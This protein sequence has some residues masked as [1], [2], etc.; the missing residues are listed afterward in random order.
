MATRLKIV[1]RQPGGEGPLRAA[2]RR[3]RGVLW[4]TNLRRTLTALALVLLAVVSYFLILRGSAARLLQLSIFLAL[5]VV[6][7]TKPHIGIVAL[8]VYRSFARGLRLEYL[9]R[10]LG[11]TLT[12]SI[13]LF[14]LIGFVALVV[15]KKEKPVFGHKTQLVFLYGFLVATLISAFRALAWAKVWTATF[16][17]LENIILYIIFVNLFA[18]TK[19]LVRYT[20]FFVLSLLV[21]CFTGIGS[22]ALSGVLRAA[23]AMG[24]PNGLAMVANFAAAMLLV[25]SLTATDVKKRFLFLC[26]LGTCLVTIIFTGSRGGL[27]TVIITFAYQLVKRRKKLIPYLLAASILVVALLMIPE[28]Y[29]SRQEQWFGALFAGETE[30]VLGGSRGYI[31][32]SALEI[33]KTSPIIGVGP[34]TFGTIY[35][36][37]YAEEARGAAEHARAVHSGVLEVLVSTGVVG[38]FFFIGLM[39]A[40]YR[41]FRE[42]E[43]LCRAAGLSRYLLLNGVYEALFIATIVAGSFETILRGGQ[44]FFVAIAAAAAINRAAVLLSASAPSPGAAPLATTEAAAGS[45][46]AG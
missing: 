41:L 7:I 1:R 5:F 38:F 46:A 34:R 45:A 22:I 36:A 42:N 32:R 33:F 35:R 9:F 44:T 20:W 3:L 30:E 19:W 29:R 2:G 17:L 14:S 27:L 11:V 21:S 23:G 24:N 13:G 8:R 4:G 40:T 37:E 43:R 26:G 15:T 6:I 12:K 18:E 25:L 39:V 16:Q 10:G 31:Y 28:Q